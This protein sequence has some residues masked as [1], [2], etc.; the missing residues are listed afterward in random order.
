[1]TIHTKYNKGN[2]LFYLHN[3]KIRS[4]KVGGFRITTDHPSILPNEAETNV[5]RITYRVCGNPD[6]PI[7]KQIWVEESKL[8]PTKEALIASL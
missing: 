6:D 1:M 4:S 7:A 5:V 8:F 3:E 2:L